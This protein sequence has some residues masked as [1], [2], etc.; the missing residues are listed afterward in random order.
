MAGTSPAMTLWRSTILRPAGLGPR[1]PRAALAA[2]M[3]RQ[4]GQRR[5][6]DP[7]D[8]SRLAQGTGPNR[9]ELLPRLH[10]EAGQPVI[11]ECVRQLQVLVAPIGRDVGGLTVE[12]DRVLGI[13]LQLLGD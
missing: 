2:H 4:E 7:V 3:R 1:P 12:I 8:S 10:G 13:D 11:V 5:R 6:R 9:F